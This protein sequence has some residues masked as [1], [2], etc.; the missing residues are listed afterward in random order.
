MYKRQARGIGAPG[1]KKGFQPGAADGKRCFFFGKITEHGDIIQD[2]A[3]KEKHVLLYDGNKVIQ[4]IRPEGAQ[5]PAVIP[6]LS[7]SLIHI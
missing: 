4:G 5:L 2:G 1:S 6:D 3:V 7:L